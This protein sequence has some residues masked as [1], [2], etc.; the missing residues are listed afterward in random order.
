MKQLMSIAFI[1]IVI[2][3]EIYINLSL[4]NL[5]SIS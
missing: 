3:F 1:K 2:V 5:H 4:L